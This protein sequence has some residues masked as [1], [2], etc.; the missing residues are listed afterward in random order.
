MHNKIK[1]YWNTYYKNSKLTEKPSDFAKFITSTLNKKKSSRIID[2]GSGN[3]RD[4][5][6]FLRKGYNVSAVDINLQA[7]KNNKKKFLKYP[8]FNFINQNISKIDQ[9]KLDKK[10]DVIYSRFFIHSINQVD[11][12]KLHHWALQNLSRNGNYCLEF[13]VDLDKRILKKST[14][15]INKSLFQFEEGHYR[16]LINPEFFLVNIIKKNFKI[17]YAEI[18]NKFSVMKLNGQ[19]DNPVLMRIVL[20]L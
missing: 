2:I 14:K 7:Y 15:K 9:I 3:F 12:N 1:N 13:R 20:G 19:T 18:S 6:Y 5:F 10:Y 8:N 11:E 17:K 4:T 16:R